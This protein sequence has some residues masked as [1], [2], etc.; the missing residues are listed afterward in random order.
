MKIRCIAVTIVLIIMA[1]S[2]GRAVTHDV[3]VKLGINQTTLTDTYKCDG[4]SGLTAGVYV[5]D[6]LSSYHAIHFEVSYTN[7]KSKSLESI[8]VK[9]SYQDDY[10]SG[11]NVYGASMRT[12]TNYIDFAAL[13]KLFPP[14]E[15]R[16]GPYVYIGPVISVLVSG[17][18]T[19][20]YIYGKSNFDVD[21]QKGVISYAFGGGV[22]FDI[23]GLRSSFDI[24]GI[25]ALAEFTESAGDPGFKNNL[26]LVTLGICLS[27]QLR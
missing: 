22:D 8:R 20:E 10:S 15:N 27:S 25:R 14:E 19:I 2:I 21:Y 7:R 12:E 4:L 11:Y 5:E 3:S 16:L 17:Q 23:K 18:G 13:L 9:D 1:A 24:R 26:F 6:Y